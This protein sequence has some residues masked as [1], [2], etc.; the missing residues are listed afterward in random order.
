ME[1]IGTHEVFATTR[2]SLV[3]AAADN[4]S[5]EAL[6]A[7]NA[8]A[9]AYWYPL[10]AFARRMGSA[11]TDAEDMAQGFFTRL[12]ENNY[13]GDAR[14]ERGRFR[15]F[16]LASFKHFMADEWKSSQ[17]QKRGGG[18]EII[19]LDAQSAEDRYRLEPVDLLDAERLF[20]RRWALTILD[21]ALRRLEAE[22][23]AAKRSH[24]FARLR[25]FIVGD[26]A[27]TYAE[28]ARVLGA[29]EA[30]VKMTVSRLRQRARELIRDEIAQTVSTPAEVEEEFRALVEA[31]RFY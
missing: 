24:V 23:A 6:A 14:S 19:S 28:E 8:L 21:Q 10:Y 16:L 15:T 12:I 3:Q 5:P 31:L 18:L 9:V 26:R 30:G 27:G 13:L 4:T 29:S 11:P 20:Q 22:L 17:R 2:W 7:L 1:S 25:P